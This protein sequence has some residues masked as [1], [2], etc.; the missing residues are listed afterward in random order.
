VEACV[1]LQQAYWRKGDVPAYREA[2]IR[3]CQ[4]DLKAREYETAWQTYE[5]F[6]NAGGDRSKVPAAT[7]LELGRAAE[8]LEN[9]DRALTEYQK[10][11]AAHPSQRPAVEAQLAAA[12]IFLKRLNRPQDALKLYE[13]AAASAVPHLDLEP[14]INAGVRDARALVPAAQAATAGS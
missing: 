5:D 7:W 2:A 12:K 6:L 10:L 4:L 1:L 9:Y 13:A 11:A 8:K 3:C 14:A